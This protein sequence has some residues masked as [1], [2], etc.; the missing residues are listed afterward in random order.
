MSATLVMVLT[1]ILVFFSPLANKKLGGPDAKPLLSFWQWMTITCCTTMS[2]GMLFWSTVEPLYHLHIPPS[3]LLFSSSSIEAQRFALS[4]MYLHWG[5]T[6]FA[7]YTVPALS[8]A[9]AYYNLNARFSISS[10]FSPIIGEKYAVQCSSFIDALA[11][12]TLV[13]GM[14][15]SLGT[16][17]LVIKGGIDKFIGEQPG[18]LALVIFLIMIAFTVSSVSGLKKGIARLSSLNAYVIIVIAV[19]VMFSVP[20][21]EIFSLIRV[22]LTSYFSDFFTRSL[23]RDLASNDNW[24]KEWSVFYWANW[25]AWAPIV[26]LFLGKIAKGYSVR[27]FIIVNF[28]IP[29]LFSILWM[30]IFSGTIIYQDVLQNGFYYNLLTQQGPEAVMYGLLSQFKFE[31]LIIAIFIF[32]SF[33]AYVTSA[34]S[35][36]EAIASLCLKKD[37]TADNNKYKISLKIIWGVIIAFIAWFMIYYSGIDGIKMISSIGGFPALFIVII[38]NVA[39]LRWFW[40]SIC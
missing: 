8:F 19:I 36:T 3:S 35:N 1:C 11:L 29:A 13:C 25:L 34:D 6:P 32:I 23:A 24:N 7:I 31:L 5:I 14:A 17:A 15:A 28:L 39:L 2:T 20:I 21:V 27:A 18:T 10:A 9:L 12:F 16:G 37:K 33:L 40:K 22:S 38:M 26:A 4:T 30:S